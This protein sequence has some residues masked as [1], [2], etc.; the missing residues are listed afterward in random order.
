MSQMPQPDKGG[1]YPPPPQR[2]NAI[3]NFLQQPR[4]VLILLAA[5]SLVAFLVE[6]AVDSA[7][8]VENHGDGDLELDGALG[9]LAFNW[10]GLALAV[11]YLYCAREPERFR[12]V[13]WLALIAL[14]ASI[15]SNLYHWLVTDTF[16]IESVF[17]PI[18]VSSGLAFLVFL[19]LF[20]GKEEQVE[21]VRA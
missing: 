11:I 8:F 16:S 1:A 4:I 2:E 10:E 17:L 15:A 3:L 6:L 19:N 13:F 5:W 9:G 18:A 12:G 7:L 20:G 21:A 14:A